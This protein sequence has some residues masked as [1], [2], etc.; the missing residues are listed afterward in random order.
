MKARL[1]ISN[2]PLF[3]V[4]LA[5]MLYSPLIQSPVLGVQMSLV[6]A[7]DSSLE[8]KKIVPFVPTP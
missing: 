6:Q 3:L 5:A 4:F 7:Q 8:S 2:M 1:L